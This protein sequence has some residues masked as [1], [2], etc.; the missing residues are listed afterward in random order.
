MTTVVYFPTVW[1]D[2]GHVCY[3]EVGVEIFT[4]LETVY[5]GGLPVRKIEHG[6]LC[7]SAVNFYGGTA[8]ALLIL[9]AA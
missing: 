1:P 4:V 3:S 8:G 7:S 6:Y 5:W 9:P 2:A